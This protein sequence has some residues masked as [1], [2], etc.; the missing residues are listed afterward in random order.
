MDAETRPRQQN[1]LPASQ[2]ISSAVDISSLPP[3]PSR[4]RN[5]GTSNAENDSTSTSP[6][7]SPEDPS[8][9]ADAAAAGARSS[10][11]LLAIDR[12]LISSTGATGSDFSFRC[13]V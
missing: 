6:A 9:A 12:R 11:G 3:Y 4:R 8:V 1:A 10:D 13:A 7:S 5:A 2:T